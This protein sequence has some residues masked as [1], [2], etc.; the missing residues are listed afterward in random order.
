[1]Q[2]CSPSLEAILSILW[3]GNSCLNC[4]KSFYEWDAGDLTLQQQQRGKVQ[5][6]WKFWHGWVCVER[7]RK[8]NSPFKQT[9]INETLFFALPK[10]GD[11]QV[12]SKI[13]N[14]VN[15]VINQGPILQNYFCCNWTA[16][17]LLQ[18]FDALCEMLS[19]FSSWHICAAIKD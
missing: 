14:F 17:K 6:S 11:S 5:Q 2:H 12:S 19:E 8:E 18:I 13:T 7:E 16:V 1:M 15:K 10:W 4:Q 3:R 9:V